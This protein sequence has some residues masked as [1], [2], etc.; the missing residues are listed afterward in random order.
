[1]NR[2]TILRDIA[3]KTSQTDIVFNLSKS[4]EPHNSKKL[5][6]LTLHWKLPLSTDHA[7]LLMKSRKAGELTPG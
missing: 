6:C 2:D 3:L 5:T 1:M 4:T 7:L